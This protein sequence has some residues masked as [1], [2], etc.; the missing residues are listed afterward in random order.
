MEMKVAVKM[1]VEVKSKVIVEVGYIEKVE[2]RN[3]KVQRKGVVNREEVQV[4]GGVAIRGKC[5]PPCVVLLGTSFLHITE[6]QDP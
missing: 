4:S 2:V 3:A 1:Q 6:P 5:L